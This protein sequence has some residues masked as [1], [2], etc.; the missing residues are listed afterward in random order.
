[1]PR[2][3]GL[4]IVGVL[5]ASVAFYFV[6]FLLYGL[7]FADLWMS[8]QG[9][10]EADFEGQNTGAYMAGGFLIT[11]LQVIGLGLTLGW[12]KA[13]DMGAAIRTAIILWA[14]FALPF[15]HYSYLYEPHH[16]PALLA[17]DAGHLLVG[18]VV[19][20]IVLTLFK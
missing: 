6:G 3:L 13:M 20:A 19:S 5:I 12:R 9:I 16:N 2:I 18:W 11:A 15:S 4:N 1:M 14:F 17:I 8:A 10:A 7:L